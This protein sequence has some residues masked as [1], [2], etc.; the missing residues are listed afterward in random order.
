[1]WGGTPNLFLLGVPYVLNSGLESQNVRPPLSRSPPGYKSDG[2]RS[3]LRQLRFRSLRRRLETPPAAN[4]DCLPCPGPPA[5]PRPVWFETKWSNGKAGPPKF[6]G[7]GRFIW[8]A[9]PSHDQQV[10]KS[11]ATNNEPDLAPR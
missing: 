11:P 5:N 10:I 4:L 6:L 3:S 1:M 2:E 8:G 7:G 9:K